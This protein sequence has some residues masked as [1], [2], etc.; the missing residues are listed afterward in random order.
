MI[1]CPRLTGTNIVGY[2][3]VD[4]EASSLEISNE[5]MLYYYKH[6]NLPCYNCI[7]NR[8]YDKE[9][10]LTDTKIQALNNALARERNMLHY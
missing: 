5:E 2:R 3:K 7:V 6:T 9:T 10:N 4:F 1:D 8:N